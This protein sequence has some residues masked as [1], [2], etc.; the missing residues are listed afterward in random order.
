MLIG[1]LISVVFFFALAP[2]IFTGQALFTSTN[3]TNVSGAAATLIGLTGLIIVA[4]FILAI[5]KG[6]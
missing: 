1:T 6:R 3:A 5:Y 2:T 4:V